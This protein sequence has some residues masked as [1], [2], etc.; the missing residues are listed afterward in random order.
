VTLGGAGSPGTSSRAPYYRDRN[1]SAGGQ[2]PGRDSDAGRRREGPVLALLMG[3]A[4]LP[5]FSFLQG[6]SF[7]R[8]LERDSQSLKNRT[9]TRNAA[10]T[11]QN[12]DSHGIL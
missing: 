11:V 9:R 2:R 5:L 7:L 3:L 12:R 1:L 4:P 10:V 6:S 8:L